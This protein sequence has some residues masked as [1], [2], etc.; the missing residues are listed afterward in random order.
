[1][2]RKKV[3]KL[4]GSKTHGWGAKKKHRG[5]GNRGGRGRAGSGKKAASKKPS[6]W[7]LPKPKG[8]SSVRQNSGRRVRT[9]NLSQLR[10]KLPSLE[11]R[12][13]LTRGKSSCEVD[14]EKAGVHKLLGAG[15]LKGVE[16]KLVVKVRD[17]SQ[18]AVQK[19]REGG[20]ELT[21]TS[22]EAKL[23]SKLSSKQPQNSSEQSSDQSSEQEG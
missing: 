19:L 14:L 12:G 4:R 16:E 15:S 20:H 6:V 17:A 23:S 7:K 18:R 3:A 2:G 10:D 1:M 22:A 5:A 13:V 11:K 8:F 21:L 9:I